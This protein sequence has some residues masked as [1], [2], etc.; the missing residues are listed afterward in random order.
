MSEPR[1]PQP[2]KVRFD[3][4]VREGKRVSVFVDGHVD[5]AGVERI[6]AQTARMLDAVLDG[7][8]YGHL[9]HAEEPAARTA[10]EPS[11]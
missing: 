9:E 5:E 11:S 8:P 7:G 3:I 4:G 10:S 6:S 1:A 2:R